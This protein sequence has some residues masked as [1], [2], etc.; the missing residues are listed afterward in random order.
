VG[1]SGPSGP[2]GPAGPGIELIVGNGKFSP[3][4][5]ETI[6]NPAICPNSSFVMA[7]YY[8]SGDGQAGVAIMVK[9]Q[10]CG[11]AFLDGERNRRFKY[12]IFNP[13]TC[14]SS[15][16]AGPCVAPPFP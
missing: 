3:S 13:T 2:T 16:C 11:S 10:C 9:L 1:A 4:G 7:T 15:L 8:D 5:S 12:V 6:N 14:N